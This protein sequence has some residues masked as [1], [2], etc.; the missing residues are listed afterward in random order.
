MVDKEEE[1][2]E[3]GESFRSQFRPKSDAGEGKEEGLIKSYILQPSSMEIL[4][5]LIGSP[6]GKVD[7]WERPVSPWHGS[8]ISHQAH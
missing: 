4:T 6:Q 8:Y 2:G 7:H 3:S 1:E 5:H